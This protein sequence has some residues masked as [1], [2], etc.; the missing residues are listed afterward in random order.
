MKS[1]LSPT[2]DDHI[3]LFRFTSE[4]THIPFQYQAAPDK[5]SASGNS[6]ESEDNQDQ[7]NWPMNW[8]GKGEAEWK[9]VEE[10]GNAFERSE[11]VRKLAVISALREE[12]DE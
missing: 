5:D 11:S 3:S 10:G 1:S 4:K 9:L 7:S 8:E 12:R 2:D 6:F